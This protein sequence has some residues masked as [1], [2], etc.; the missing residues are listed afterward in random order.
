MSFYEKTVAESARR[1]L[2]TTYSASCTSATACKVKY[3]STVMCFNAKVWTQTEYCNMP[4]SRLEKVGNICARR[5]L[6]SWRRYFFDSFSLHSILFL[7]IWMLYF[8]DFK[9]DTILSSNRENK[10]AV[11]IWCMKR[12]ENPPHKRKKWH[13][14][15]METGF[16][17]DLKSIW[18][19]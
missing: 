4:V 14:I 13:G 5:S 19:F 9:I 17:F 15:W 11:R 7:V 2:W 18:I 3:T 6:L 8:P 12:F 1:L 16:Q 10:K